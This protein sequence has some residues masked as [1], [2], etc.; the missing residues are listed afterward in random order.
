MKQS[1]VFLV[2]VIAVVA[3]AGS[4]TWVQCG[5][6]PDLMGPLKVVDVYALADGGTAGVTLMDVTGKRFAFGVRGDLY[7]PRERFPAYVQRWPDLPFAREA[8]FGGEEERKLAVLAKR[9]SHDNASDPTLSTHIGA[10]GE[11]LEQRRKNGS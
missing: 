6:V 11:L 2:A 8:E 10:I 1:R 5:R 3:M 4:V 7:T 9:A